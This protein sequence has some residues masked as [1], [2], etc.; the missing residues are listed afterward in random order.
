ML[1]HSRLKEYLDYDPLTGVFVWL[2]KKARANPGDVAGGFS[3]NHG[4]VTI[5]FD[6]KH[7]MAHRLAWFYMR[8]VW[9]KSELD[10]EDTDRSNNRWSNLREATSGQNKQNVQKPR[11][12]N[13]LGFLGVL[14][15]GEKFRAYITTG[16]KQRWL[17]TFPT[18]EEAHEAYLT[19]KRSDHSHNLL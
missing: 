16:K 19:A 9:P 15:R 6:G 5:K 14:R 17:G 7:Y 4:Y 3:R 1:S 12:H 11:S 8:G 18:P 13:K 2:K 10:H